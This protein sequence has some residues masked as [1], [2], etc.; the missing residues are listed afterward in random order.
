MNVQ[1]PTFFII[2]APKCGTTSLAKWLAGHPEIFMSAPK[3]PHY[4][5]TDMANRNLPSWDEYISLFR[6][7]G[8]EHKAVGEAS[9]WYL[10]SLDAVAAI[11]QCFDAPR[12]I[13]MT[14]DPVEMA[15]SLYQHN[16]RHLHED[17][18]SFEAAWALQEKRAEG[19][20]ISATCREPAFLKYQQACA[21][22]SMLERLL[23]TV[24]NH[25]VLHIPLEQIKENPQHEYLRTLRFLGV[26]DDS[27]RAFRAEN[28]ARMYKSR[29][30]QKA[31]MIGGRMRA[32]MGIRKGFGLTR[33]NESKR[34]KA[35]LSS[36][37]FQELREAFSE[38]RHKLRRISEGNV[39]HDK[40]Y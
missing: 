6:N 9:T 22:G 10:Y 18:E 21:L 8:H 16:V 7:V 30:L 32:K 35:E 20:H 4:F 1:K 26:E 36:D 3:E 14:R 37:F 23:D 5:N 39:Q 25:R 24:P 27:R 15:Q 38:E 17:A 19:K 40:G 28:E 29:I 2:G 12:Y 11:E 34:E 31:L 13:V 33:L